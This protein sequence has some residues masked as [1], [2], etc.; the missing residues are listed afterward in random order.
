MR[1]GQAEKKE[2]YRLQFVLGM[3]G[4]QAES[5]SYENA[6]QK[7]A[8]QD[9]GYRLQFVLGM[10]GGQAGSLS[11]WSAGWAEGRPRREA[12]ADRRAADRWEAVNRERR[13]RAWV[14]S[15]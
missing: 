9:A 13:R 14:E 3:E 6:E 15:L 2:G 11:Y 5:L 7:R 8:E 4:G 12:A 1:R 10:G